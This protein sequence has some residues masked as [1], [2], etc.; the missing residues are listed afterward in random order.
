MKG[1]H[2]ATGKLGEEL[3]KSYL[4]KRGCHILEQNYRTKYGEIDLV[5]QKGNRTVFVEVR[6]RVG[7]QFGLPE[8]TLNSKKKRKVM[9]N[10]LAYMT[11]KKAKNP[12]QIDAVCVVLNSEGELVRLNHYESICS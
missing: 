10:A 1:E 7:E 12:Y 2:L 5:V 11:R 8:E 4:E 3:A 6:T 9:S